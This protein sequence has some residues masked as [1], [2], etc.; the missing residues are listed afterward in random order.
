MIVTYRMGIAQV[1]DECQT[2]RRLRI[3]V[4]DD[5]IDRPLTQNGQCLLEVFGLCESAHPQT[6][7]QVFDHRAHEL[8]VVDNK[9]AQRLELWTANHCASEIPAFQAASWVAPSGPS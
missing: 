5:K 7:T 1:F 2:V 9:N 4:G 3:P 6:F 8:V